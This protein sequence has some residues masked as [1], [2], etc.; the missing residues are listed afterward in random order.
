MWVK[1]ESAGTWG[2]GSHLLGSPSCSR[3]H[4]MVDQH[5]RGL[6]VTIFP[7]EKCPAFRQPSLIADSPGRGQEAP[8]PV[9]Q[10]VAGVSAI[11]SSLW[12]IISR[13]TVY[14]RG[15][16]RP[17]W[18]AGSSPAPRVLPT[19]QVTIPPP[20]LPALA[21]SL[22]N[23]LLMFMNG[24]QRSP[25]PNQ[26]T[27]KALQKNQG[28]VNMTTTPPPCINT[29]FLQKHLQQPLDKKN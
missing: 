11:S 9:P 25:D 14:L 27:D 3:E 21:H 22:A 1:E 2:G 10:M 28:K 24:I 6:Q 18:S 5:R 12:R 17:R 8:A 7:E 29:C 20:L 13:S 4:M 23:V 16:R 19:A 15:E 26:M